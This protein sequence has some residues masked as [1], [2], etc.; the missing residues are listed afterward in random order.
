MNI[1]SLIVDVR[2]EQLG[3]VRATLNGWSGVEVPAAS[4]QGKLVVTLESPSDTETTETIARINALDGV[5]SV[6]MVYHQIEPNPDME[7]RDDADTT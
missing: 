7:V 6:A 1:S 3:P 2:P 4:P 5:L